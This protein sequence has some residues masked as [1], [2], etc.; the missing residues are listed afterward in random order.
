MNRALTN[1]SGYILLVLAVLAGIVLPQLQPGAAGKLLLVFSAGMGLLSGW[2]IYFTPNIKQTVMSVVLTLL[3][4]ASAYVLIV[5]IALP[6][7]Q[8]FLFVTDVLFSSSVVALG[9]LLGLF[10]A[11][12]HEQKKTIEKNA[13]TG[14]QQPSTLSVPVQ[15][16][17]ASLKEILRVKNE[18][19]EE[20]SRLKTEKSRL[21]SDIK[22]IIHTELELI[23]RYEKENNEFFVKKITA[24]NRT[25]L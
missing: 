22:R 13:H 15:E 5:A 18:T 24:E 16:A 9:T 11:G 3:I 17:N 12:F 7:A 14:S 21:V 10:A 1:N 6:S 23:N 25:D 20:V 19:S 8:S 2:Y 4:T